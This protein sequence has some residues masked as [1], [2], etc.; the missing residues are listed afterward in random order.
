MNPGTEFQISSHLRNNPSEFRKLVLALQSYGTQPLAPC[1]RTL[2][3]DGLPWLAADRGPED[4]MAQMLRKLRADPLYNTHPEVLIEIMFRVMTTSV[5]LR[6][7]LYVLNNTEPAFT[8]DS[9]RFPIRDPKGLKGR[10]ITS[11]VLGNL[12]SELTETEMKRLKTLLSWEIVEGCPHIPRGRLES[13]DGYALSTA[14]E[15]RHGTDAAFL[16]SLVFAY[17]ERNDLVHRIVHEAVSS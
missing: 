8:T 10:V 13:M 2:I 17:L 9:M 4:V 1:V 11:K 15:S 12:L 7:V 16:M 14:I 6:L 3:V 5:G